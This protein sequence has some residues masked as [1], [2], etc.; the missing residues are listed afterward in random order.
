MIFTSTSENVKENYKINLMNRKG[1]TMCS[2]GSLDESTRFGGHTKA[3]QNTSG[4]SYFMKREIIVRRSV[5]L[6]G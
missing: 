3:V 6:V 2:R 4:L 5:N 1:F